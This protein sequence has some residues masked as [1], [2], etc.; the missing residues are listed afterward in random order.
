MKIEEE[1]V[2][3]AYLSGKSMNAIAREFHT[4]ATS[5]RRILSHNNIKLR[6]DSKRKGNFYVQDGEKLIEWAK[7]QDRLVTKTEL[8]QVIGKKRLSPSYFIKHPELGH[9]VKS[10]TQDDLEEYYQKLYNWLQKNHIDYKPNDRTRLRVS[11]DALLLGE[12]SDIAIQIL[13]KPKHV[14]KKRHD[15]NM[16]LKMERATKAGV[17]MILLNKE[18][19]GNLDEIKEILD[20]LKHQD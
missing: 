9:Y 14:S 18:H 16:E 20:K 3:E 2:I 8:A 11:V 5:V 7:A 15:D 12:Y 13:E 4:Y 19:F 10:E 6:H 1:K 17:T